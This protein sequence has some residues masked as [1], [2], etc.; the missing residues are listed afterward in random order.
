MLRDWN[1]WQRMGVMETRAGTGKG[2]VRKTRFRHIIQDGCAQGE[3][4]VWV[5]PASL[6]FRGEGCARVHS[7]A[8]GTAMLV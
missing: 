7:R 6:K 3:A 4:A 5:L 8:V 1:V 2:G